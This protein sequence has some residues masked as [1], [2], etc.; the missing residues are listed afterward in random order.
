MLLMN[1][2]PFHLPQ[3][4]RG[5]KKMVQYCGI[6]PHKPWLITV[7]SLDPGFPSR[8]GPAGHEIQAQKFCSEFFFLSLGLDPESLGIPQRSLG[9]PATP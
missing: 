9:S 8:L 2:W 1:H 3:G 5:K 6:C 7:Q 4:T